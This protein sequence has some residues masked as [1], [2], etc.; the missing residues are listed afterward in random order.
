LA[1]REEDAAPAGAVEWLNSK[2]LDAEDLRGKVVPVD[3]WTFTCINWRRTLPYLRAW[4]AM[5]IDYP[6]AIDSNYRIWQAFDNQYWPAL[7][8]IDA[9]EHIRRRRFGE[10]EYERCEAGLQQLLREGGTMSTRAM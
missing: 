3:F 6:I 1:G 8:L 4:R 2:P 9:H 5:K 7:Y 10:G